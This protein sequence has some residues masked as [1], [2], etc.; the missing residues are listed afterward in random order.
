MGTIVDTSKI[1][2]SV[3]ILTRQVTH[4]YKYK[5]F[6]IL[7]SFIREGHGYGHTALNPRP[8][9]KHYIDPYNINGN[10]IDRLNEFSITPVIPDNQ[11]IFQPRQV[12]VEWISEKIKGH[13][14]AIRWYREEVDEDDPFDTATKEVNRLVILGRR[15]TGKSKLKVILTADND[16]LNTPEEPHHI[17]KVI[18]YTIYDVPNNYNTIVERYLASVKNLL[19]VF[20]VIK[21][22][23]GVTDT[24]RIML[25]KL[26]ELGQ[27]FTVVITH[28]DRPAHP[29]YLFKVV[30]SVVNMLPNFPAA[31]QQPFL[32]SNITGAGIKYLRTYICYCTGHLKLG[33]GFADEEENLEQFT[34][35]GVLANKHLLKEEGAPLGYVEKYSPPDAYRPNYPLTRSKELW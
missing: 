22:D 27:P 4:R 7:I 32:V 17:S 26:N 31:F 30:R 13:R 15:K 9:I 14:G 20:V 12:E 33:V 8:L 24:D 5:S 6:P 3:C 29:S 34:P 2:M 10:P 19:Q 23:Q 1:T 11:Y 28:Q 35:T 18:L 16:P 25:E 21:A